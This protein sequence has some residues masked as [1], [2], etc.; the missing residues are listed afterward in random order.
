MAKKMS[1]S[2]IGAGKMGQA[3]VRRLL[4][5]TEEFPVE[6]TVSDHKLENMQWLV[7]NHPEVRVTTSNTE[8]VQGAEI[9]VLC[10]KPSNLSKVAEQ[11]RGKLAPETL[12][13]SILAGARIGTIQKSLGCEKVVRAMPNT[14]GQIGQGISGWCCSP[15]LSDE[16]KALAVK[17]LQTL[18]PEV[19]FE[20]EKYLDI[21]TAISGSGPGLVYLYM[22]VVEDVAVQLGMPRNFAKLLVTQTVLGSAAYAQS[23]LTTTF[24]ELR[25]EVTSPDGTTAVGGYVL[26]RKGFRAGIMEAHIAMVE[27]CRSL[28]QSK[29]ETN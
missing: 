24:A 21:A 6:L 10:V 2:F 5:T 28:G 14:P 3:M 17:V 9:V 11:I 18:G 29:T 13:V 7:E 15:A 26:E 27:K 12:V 19:F 1:V 20:D 16:H 22:E 25:H 8:C 23:R 4:E